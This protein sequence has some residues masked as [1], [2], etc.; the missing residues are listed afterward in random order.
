M[1]FDAPLLVV[2]LLLAVGGALFVANLAVVLRH[3]FAPDKSR[4]PPR[5]PTRRLVMNLL[6]G[7]LVALWAGVTLIVRF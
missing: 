1:I 3:R 5:P 2:Q 7:G 4:L 6:I